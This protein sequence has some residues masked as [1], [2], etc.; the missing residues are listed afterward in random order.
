MGFIGLRTFSA[1]N[2]PYHSKQFLESI[3][4]YLVKVRK[5]DGTN[6]YYLAQRKLFYS[7]IFSSGELPT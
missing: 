3:F 1:Q 6:K 7:T 4:P 5:T 2:M